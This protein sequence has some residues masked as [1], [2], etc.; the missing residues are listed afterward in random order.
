MYIYKG[1][2]FTVLIIMYPPKCS[3]DLP[4][5]ADLYTRTPFQLCVYVC[6]CVYVCVHVCMHVNMHVCMN[7][8]LNLCVQF[9]N[10]S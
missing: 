3:D 9:T 10:P 1:I 8:C 2:R 7:A 6:A 5:L 4:P